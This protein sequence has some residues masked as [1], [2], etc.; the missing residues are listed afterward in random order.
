[1]GCGRTGAHGNSKTRLTE[2]LINSKPFVGK[3]M[4]DLCVPLGRFR[5]QML[6]AWIL[7]A[8][9]IREGLGSVNI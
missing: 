5:E 1:M 7:S 8:E 9:K 4:P 6:S 2:S 3:A